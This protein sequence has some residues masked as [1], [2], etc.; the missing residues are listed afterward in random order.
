MSA[1]VVVGGVP[2]DLDGDADDGKP[3]VWLYADSPEVVRCDTC[4]EQWRTHGRGRR[5]YTEDFDWMQDGCA[6]VGVEC[7]HCGREY[8]A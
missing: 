3:R 6:I 4:G 8:E 2:L 7:A 1:Y 5:I